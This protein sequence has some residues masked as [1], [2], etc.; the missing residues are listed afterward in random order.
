M[1][2]GTCV[3]CSLAGVPDP[4]AHQWHL[5]EQVAENETWQ[6]REQPETQA[7]QDWL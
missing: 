5:R 7:E 3:S 6:A 1:A 4:H 2:L